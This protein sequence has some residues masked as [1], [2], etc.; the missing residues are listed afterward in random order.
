MGAGLVNPVFT[1]VAAHLNKVKTIVDY[2]E[3]IGL[4][5]LEYKGA[6]ELYKDFEGKSK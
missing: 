4:K 5:G 2:A 6:R 1:A 3:K